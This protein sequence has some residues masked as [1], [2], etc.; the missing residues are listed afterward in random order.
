MFIMNVTKDLLFFRTKNKKL[1]F[2]IMLRDYFAV[3]F[4]LLSFYQINL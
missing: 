1:L 4:L 3:L 2:S